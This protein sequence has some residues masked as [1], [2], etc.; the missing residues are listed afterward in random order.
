MMDLLGHT[1]DTT[2]ISNTYATG[3]SSWK[4][5]ELYGLDLLGRI[6]ELQVSMNLYATGFKS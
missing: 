2:T 3:D 4:L 6:I 5:L 1:D